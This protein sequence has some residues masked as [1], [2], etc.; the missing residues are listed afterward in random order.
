MRAR[1]EERLVAQPGGFDHG[2]LNLRE[3]E[4][5]LAAGPR[6][7]VSGSRGIDARGAVS[8]GADAGKRDAEHVRREP[9]QPAASSAARRAVA[10]AGRVRA[11]RQTLY[12]RT[13]WALTESARSGH[14]RAESPAVEALAFTGRARLHARAASRGRLRTARK[15][16]RARRATTSKFSTQRVR[17]GDV[18]VGPHDRDG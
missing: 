6:K 11:W 7:S 15:V 2:G 14:A 1:G 5:P 12:L 3:G 4:Q 16:R 13:G 8:S 17:H 9:A 18:A 10:A